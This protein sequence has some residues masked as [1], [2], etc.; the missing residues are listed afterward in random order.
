MSLQRTDEPQKDDISEGRGRKATCPACKLRLKQ[1]AER[2][3]LPAIENVSRQVN[4]L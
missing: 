3:S 2:Q 4:N 1:E